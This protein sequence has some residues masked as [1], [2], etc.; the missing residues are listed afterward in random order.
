I[1]DKPRV[2]SH[3]VT[4]LKRPREPMVAEQ[5]NKMLYRGD[6]QGNPTRIRQ[7]LLSALAL[8]WLVAFNLPQT[9]AVTKQDQSNKPDFSGSWTLDLQASTSLEPL[10]NQIGA[11]SLDRKYA[12]QTS[13]KAK[14]EQT[15][16]ALKVSTRGP[17]FALDQ[18]LYLDGRDDSGSLELLGAT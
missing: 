5:V 12:A 9:F 16:D 3:N 6:W 4:M 2:R 13:L 10:M 14:L 11:S 15:E 18:T 1:Q 7:V 17:G 8:A